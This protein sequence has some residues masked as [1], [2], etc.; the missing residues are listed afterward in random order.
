MGRR[1]RK[2]AKRKENQFPRSY[3]RRQIIF[4]YF[5]GLGSNISEFGSRTISSEYYVHN[6]EKVVNEI[7]FSERKKL[8]Y[9]EC[10]EV[11]EAIV[12]QNPKKGKKVFLFKET[13]PERMI[14]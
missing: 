7:F 13:T 2:R 11:L 9:L 5:E 10:V 12:C 4:D 8:S 3:E 14:S 6:F 1:H